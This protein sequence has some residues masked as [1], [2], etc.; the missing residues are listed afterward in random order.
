MSQSMFNWQEGW[1]SN[2]V[3]SFILFDY[4][5]KDAR[6]DKWTQL[7]TCFFYDFFVHEIDYFLTSEILM[8]VTKACNSDFHRFMLFITFFYLHC[9]HLPCRLT[10]VA[11]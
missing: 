2:R 11:I 7:N 8:R 6:G 4:I 9:L 3:N 5:Q 10:H 1:G